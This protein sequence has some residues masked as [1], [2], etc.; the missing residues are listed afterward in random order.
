MLRPPYTP[1][2]PLEVERIHN[3]IIINVTKK[4]QKLNSPSSLSE[5]LK[6]RRNE[7]LTEIRPQQQQ[8]QQQQQ[9]TRQ[10]ERR[11]NINNYN[12]TDYMKR[13]NTL[14]SSNRSCIFIIFINIC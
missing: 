14:I 4:Y 10:R 13:D 1:S 7:S 2:Y 8:L 11:E 12:K 5:A 6:F 9:R 3:L